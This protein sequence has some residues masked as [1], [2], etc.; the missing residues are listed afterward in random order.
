MAENAK[1]K[2]MAIIASK[3]TLDMAYAPLV[4]GATAAALD[5]DVRIFFAFGGINILHKERN[6]Q[7]PPPAG[8]EV[9]PQLAKNINWAGIPEMLQMC[10]DAGVKFVACSATMQMMGYKKEDLVDGIE[11]ADA[12]RFVEFAQSA[13]TSL[14]I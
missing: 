4:L 3:G 2:S 14:F 6:R 12:D 7:I 9:L 5:T 11:V 13:Q 10:R 1:G 8:M